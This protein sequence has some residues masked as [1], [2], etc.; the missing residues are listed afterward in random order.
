MSS[1][2]WTVQMVSTVPCPHKTASL[3]QFPLWEQWAECTFQGQRKG[4]GA[5][6][7]L[8]PALKST[9]SHVLLMTSS[10]DC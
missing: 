3:E 7:C 1:V 10:N 5:S 9:G 4:A 8:G 6:D 2:T